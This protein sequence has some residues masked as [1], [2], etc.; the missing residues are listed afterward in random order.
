L[1][2]EQREVRER[3]R[4]LPAD[5]AARQNGVG[6]LSERKET[7]AEEV[8]QLES[9]LDRLA[10][11][12]HGEQP[13]AAE[14]L[15]ATV[16]D[17]RDKRLQ[18]KIRYSRGVIAERSSEYAEAFEESIAGDLDALRDGIAEAVGRM[19]EPEGQRRERALDRARDVAR[20]LESLEERARDGAGADTG[21]VGPQAGAGDRQR[22][23]RGEAR[24]RAGELRELER[25]LGRDGV[26][27]GPL[28][29]IARRL[30]RMDATGAIGTPRGLE[31]LADA[32]QALKDFE[33]ALR[34]QLVGDS[35]RPPVLTA[36]ED[37]PP[38]Y[39]ALVEEYY[40]RLAERRR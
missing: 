38:E 25:E 4:D 5:P 13:E 26:D 18:D 29:E 11:D 2:E 33:F 27:V 21:G 37:V 31:Q 23:L 40:R 12:T 32:I 14:Q 1:V 35:T 28:D 36:G 16:K 19:G 24:R 22:Q 9:E 8:D 10:R 3:L 7:M 17:L 39:R 6:Q 30:E 34:R 20:A 15:R